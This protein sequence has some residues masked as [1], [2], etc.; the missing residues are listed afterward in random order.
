MWYNKMDR[1]Y[2]SEVEGVIESRGNRIFRELVRLREKRGRDKSG[3]FFCEGERLV[4]SI[5]ENIIK[6]YVFRESVED[7]FI[8]G[9]D[10]KGF[11]VYI[12]SDR[13]FREVSDTVSS[14]GVICV[15]EKPVADMGDIFTKKPEFIIV[16]ED[17]QDPGNMGTVIRT[18]DAGGAGGVI[19]TKGCVDVYSPKVLRSAMGSVFN[20][21]VVT[22]ADAG[23]VTELL[24][25]KGILTLSAHLRGTLTPYE[26]NLKLPVAIYVGNEA[27]GLR[28]E[29]AEKTDMLIR[30]PII[31]GAESLN[32]SVA[33]GILIYEV[34]R[35]RGGYE[36]I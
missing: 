3:L 8:E 17:I 36:K 29:T 7:G 2:C 27:N 4:R 31:G 35:Q 24:K 28:A 19:L 20:L 5:P 11:P 34:V 6:Y 1:L 9:F 21:P 26:V 14:Q 32:A 12:F 15:C 23:A 22:G 25:S 10:T 18:A 30:L 33:C 13:L 16:C